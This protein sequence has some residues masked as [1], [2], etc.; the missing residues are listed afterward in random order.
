MPV[1]SSTDLQ[2]TAGK[3][4]VAYLP[5]IMYTQIKLWELPL[6]VWHDIP[7]K[8][9]VTSDICKNVILLLSEQIAATAELG[10]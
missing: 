7:C 3:I 8:A 5:V 4:S 9:V 6:I 10:W 2:E 1:G